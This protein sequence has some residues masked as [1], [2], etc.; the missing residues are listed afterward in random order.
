MGSTY[1]TNYNY[2]WFIYIGWSVSILVLLLIIINLFIDNT[3][4]LFLLI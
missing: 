2:S 4:S 1:I 3:K